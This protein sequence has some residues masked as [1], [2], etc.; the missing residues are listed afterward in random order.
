MHNRVVRLTSGDV[1]AASQGLDQHGARRRDL[2]V[3]LSV[4]ALWRL[5][6]RGTSL[7]PHVPTGRA[8]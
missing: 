6:L 5:P 8:L 1:L 7:L 2:H 4:G 3:C